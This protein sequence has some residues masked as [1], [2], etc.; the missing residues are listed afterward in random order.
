MYW[1]PSTCLGCHMVDAPAW[2]PS[3]CLS[4]GPSFWCSIDPAHS[5][6]W[7]Q[8]CPASGGSSLE[9]EE[10]LY[11][12]IPDVSDRR[13]YLLVRPQPRHHSWGVCSRKHGGRASRLG[14][15]SAH[16]FSCLLACHLLSIWLQSGLVEIQV[17]A[18]LLLTRSL[19]ASLHIE[20]MPN[21]SLQW[22]VSPH[23]HLISLTSLTLSLPIAVHQECQAGKLQGLALLLLFPH[24]L[25][26]PIND[27][28]LSALL[29]LGLF[30][31]LI[32]SIA[33]AS[34]FPALYLTTALITS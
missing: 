3:L 9:E 29:P 21:E 19:M 10:G 34:P 22:L 12:E 20:L 23:P 25:I 11:L 28:T 7:G 16:P 27:G 33:P 13:D 14:R 4:R 2:V 26:S 31:N 1:A 24:P 32:F 5:F 15:T 8:L 6:V 17:I 18:C 30:S